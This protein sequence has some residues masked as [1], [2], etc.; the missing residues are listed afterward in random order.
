MFILL[1]DHIR[2]WTKGIL[3]AMKTN[4][5]ENIFINIMHSVHI[6][7]YSGLT[8]QNCEWFLSK[9]LIGAFMHA[10]DCRLLIA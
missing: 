3:Y 5:V 7:I 8:E 2:K 4:F 9:K 10:S 1:I 6:N